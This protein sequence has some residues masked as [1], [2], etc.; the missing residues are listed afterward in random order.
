M[1]TD[2]RNDDYDCRADDDDGDDDGDGDD[3]DGD[4]DDY[5]DADDDDDDGDGDG[6]D[7][8]RDDDDGDDSAW[9]FFKGRPPFGKSNQISSALTQLFSISMQSPPAP[10]HFEQA[11]LPG[12]RPRHNTGQRHEDEG[13][14]PTLP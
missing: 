5:C 2:D 14:H 13:R 7:D 3:D 4:G 12:Q 10:Q 6:D 11:P 1:A 8:D 9:T